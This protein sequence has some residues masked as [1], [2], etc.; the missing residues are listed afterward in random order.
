MVQRR[1]STP[2]GEAHQQSSGCGRAGGGAGRDLEPHHRSGLRG[3]AGLSDE[4][5]RGF[6]AHVLHES[7]RPCGDGEYRRRDHGKRTF[8]QR[9]K[10][11][12]PQH[13]FR[14]LG[15]QSFHGAV[16]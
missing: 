15:E 2:R 13:E 12:E 11:P 4:A 3:E 7:T 8:V 9:S 10:A 16:S 1:M 6:G 5:V 14:P